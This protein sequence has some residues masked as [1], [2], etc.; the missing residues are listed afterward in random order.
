MSRKLKMLGGPPLL[1]ALSM[2]LAACGGGGGSP[3]PANAAPVAR[4]ADVAPTVY[5]GDPVVLDG[6]SSTDADNDPL[7]FEWSVTE[8]PAGSTVQ[9]GT[10]APGLSYLIPDT[11]G[12]YSVVMRVSDGKGGESRLTRPLDVQSAPAL[13]ITLDQPEPLGGP[14]QLRLSRKVN[15]NKVTWYVDSNQLGQGKQDDAGLVT[16]DASYQTDGPHLIQARLDYGNGI[17]A[18]VERQVQVKT[19]S[20]KLSRPYVWYH[21]STTI[22]V[23]A[24]SVY[25]VDR[26]TLSYQGKVL[27]ELTA[28]NACG[29]STVCPGP[30]TSYLFPVSAD[31][32]GS[33]MVTLDLHA[34]DKSGA[35]RTVQVVA[36]V[37]PLVTL[38][39]P[40]AG[41][42]VFDSFTLNGKREQAHSEVKVEVK[43]GDQVVYTQAGVGETFSTPISVAGLPAGRYT[44][45][46]SARDALDGRTYLT[47]DIV[48]VQEA[49]LALPP[50]TSLPRPSATLLAADAS[51]FWYTDPELTSAGGTVRRVNLSTLAATDLPG[52]GGVSVM[53][54]KSTPGH[55][56][57]ET[58][59][60]A[61][62]QLVA[63]NCIL[64]WSGQG[65]RS[66]LSRASGR[67]VQL[68]DRVT[69]SGLQVS[70]NLVAWTSEYPNQAL[71]SYRLDTSQLRQKAL[72]AG[73]TRAFGTVAI[74]R[75]PASD[76]VWA[77]LEDE[78]GKARLYQWKLADD[79]L[80]SPGGLDLGPAA[81]W[82]S[83][84]GNDDICWI[85]RGT[86]AT[87]QGALKCVRLST[88]EI[89][90]LSDKASALQLDQDLL[91]WREQL[92][93]SSRSY[94]ALNL[95]QAGPAANVSAPSTL[96]S[97]FWTGQGHVIFSEGDATYAWKASTGTKTLI[98][99]AAAGSVTFSTG[100]ALLS[101]QGQVYR[102]SLPN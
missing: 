65:V 4:M 58:N 81:Q 101:Y 61:G 35:S 28:P 50:L 68:T 96:W 12:R 87:S 6:R 47:R 11:A 36:Q 67:G 16:W 78:Q 29:E 82:A 3:A 33:G 99:G 93:A 64:D 89:R 71:L 37:N 23:E 72:P 7:S 40:A 42:F 80:Q 76:E 79:S 91:V 24:Q 25:G 45:T 66:N 22:L 20:I 52:S 83:A 27:S 77:L 39:A 63:D 2:L 88:L 62:C 92:D 86:P 30:Y 57:G 26:L 49:R 18:Q 84:S 100:A 31:Q 95:R 13:G 5:T 44:L 90:T 38:T 32:T 17:S 43:L 48:V 8:R 75:L 98:M 51:Y 55:V 1:L 46:V 14:V 15:F 19:P 9:L 10:S 74:R 70:G 102:V 53:T 56:L 69:D 34:R 21:G 59:G 97:Q 60:T 41:A 54:L 94:K 73:L 85:A